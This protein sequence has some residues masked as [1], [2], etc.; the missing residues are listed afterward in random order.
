M[1]FATCVELS[2][3]RGADVIGLHPLH[4]LF[5]DDPEH[6]SPYSTAD[7]RRFTRDPVNVPATSDE[8]TG[9]VACR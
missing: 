2:A 8:P 9:A 3:D 5:P 1:I 7:C 6:A 4:A